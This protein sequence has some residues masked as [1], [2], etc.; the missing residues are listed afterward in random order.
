[1]GNAH[2]ARGGPGLP[3]VHPHVHGERLW[4][5]RQDL[6]NTGSSP[7]TWGT[8]RD[9]Q[10]KEVYRRFIPTYMGN[11]W[12]RECRFTTRSVHP[13]VHGERTLISEG[14]ARE[15]GSSPRTWGTLDRAGAGVLGVRF[16]PTYMGNAHTTY[17]A[18]R[19]PQVHPHVHGERS[20][21]R[22]RAAWMNGS[23]PRTWGTQVLLRHESLVARFIPT[24]MG[25][26][27]LTSLSTSNPTVHPH[28]H[29][30]RHSGDLSLSIA[31][32]SSPRTWGTHQ[33]EIDDQIRTRFIPTYMGNA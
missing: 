10:P 11:A 27:Q 15:I 8:L 19:S 32:G 9:T 7:R 25:N 29:G 4:A 31:T 28:V 30:E 6:R 22:R 26:A 24:Y 33:D 13:H 2:R 12:V 21:R 14:R 5:G 20:S 16:I 18:P 23:S 1:M 17:P 3:P